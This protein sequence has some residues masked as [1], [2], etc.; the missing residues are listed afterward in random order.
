MRVF[1]EQEKWIL[2]KTATIKEVK[3]MHSISLGDICSVFLDN[4]YIN[5]HFHDKN[6]FYSLRFFF[7]HVNYSLKDGHVITKKQKEIE[8]KIIDTIFLLKFLKENNLLFE[9]TDHKTSE[10]FNILKSQYDI[11][12]HLVFPTNFDNLTSKLVVET[13]VNKRYF[14][15]QE[16]IDFIKNGFKTAEE[17]RFEKSHTATWIGITIAFIIGTISILLVA[18]PSKSK[19]RNHE[20]QT[21]QI[22]Y[23]ES[24]VQLFIRTQKSAMLLDS[25]LLN[26]INCNIGALN[27]NFISLKNKATVKFDEIQFRQLES[28]IKRTQEIVLQMD[29]MLLNSNNNSI[30]TSNKNPQ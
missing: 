1:S 25:T 11:S 16:F 26:S 30:E 10:E 20:E 15:R 14:I 19:I 4:E 29:S 24:S 3:N 12:N 22:E 23:L 13:L 21:K 18:F 5:V 17:Y 27:S 6:K 8:N 9:I 28:L 7:N 2:R